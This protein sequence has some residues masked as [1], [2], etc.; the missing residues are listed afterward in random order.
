MGTTLELVKDMEQALARGESDMAP[1][2]HEDFVWD[3]NAG[4]GRKTGLDDFRDGWQAPFRTAFGDRSYH[5]SVWLEDGDW[6]ACIGNCQATHAG[7]FMGM[8]ATGRPV[9]IPYIDFWRI[10]GTKIAE[11]I[12]RVDF[13]SVVE[14]LGGDVFEGR[15]WGTA[16]AAD[17]DARSVS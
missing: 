6:A 14:Q 1:W 5:T 7:D 2:F 13:A 8:P 17:H 9:R 10:E 11:N 3:G 4:C 12:V 16:T 15:G